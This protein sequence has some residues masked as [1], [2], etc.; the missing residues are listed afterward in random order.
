MKKHLTL[1]SKV[2]RLFVKKEGKDL[3]R[4]CVLGKK[5]IFP[6]LLKA[7]GNSYNKTIKP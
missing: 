4:L 5:E 2:L 1:V 6:D 3:Q 7:T